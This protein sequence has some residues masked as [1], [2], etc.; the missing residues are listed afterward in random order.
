MFNRKF[1]ISE[2]Y[3]FGLRIALDYFLYFMVAVV[4]GVCLAA[5]FLKFVGYLD[6]WDN[7][8]QHFSEITRFF[9]ESMKGAFGSAGHSQYSYDSYVQK[10]APT[11]VAQFFSNLKL[12]N[13]HFDKVEIKSYLKDFLP[14]ILGFKFM[15]DLIGVGLSKMSLDVYDKKSVTFAHF[16]KFYALVPAYFIVNLIVYVA[17]VACFVVA[18][19]LLGGINFASVLFLIPGLFLYQRLR[20]AKFFVIDKNNNI[21]QALRASWCATADC[22]THLAGFSFVEMLINSLG[23]LLILTSFVIFPLRY[24][25]EVSVYRQIV[26]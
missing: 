1:S 16:Y 22:W 21:I 13:F 9:H 5:L 11:Q 10:W 18:D 20:F 2:A 4:V 25:V 15:L 24:P 17:T 19:L 12:I 6:S 26:K 23:H 7:F 14:A 8:M 3:S